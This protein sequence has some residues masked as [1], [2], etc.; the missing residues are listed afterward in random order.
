MQ[1]L[2]LMLVSINLYQ[3]EAGED[4]D[5]GRYHPWHHEGVVEDPFSDAGGAGA[6]KVDCRY[7]GGVIGN[8]EIAVYCREEGYEHH[9]T[10]AKGY[11]KRHYCPDGGCLTIQEY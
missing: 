11:A 6:V 9:R 3:Q 1:W 7:D 8:E 5:Y 2:G 10:D 4:G